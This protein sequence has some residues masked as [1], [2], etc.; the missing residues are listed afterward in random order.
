MVERTI[1]A[2]ALEKQEIPGLQWEVRNKNRLDQGKRL[3]Y[4]MVNIPGRFAPEMVVV[5]FAAPRAKLTHKSG[6]NW[7]K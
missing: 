3:V 4:Y 7:K 5:Q 2:G 6:T 1:P